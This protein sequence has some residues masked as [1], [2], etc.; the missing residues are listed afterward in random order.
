MKYKKTMYYIYYVL[1][2]LPLAATVVSL[3]FLPECIPAH[4]GENNQVTR[5]GSKYETLIFPA[6]TIIVG[7]VMLG[8]AKSA[9]GKEK[10]KKDSEST[11]IIIGISVL[12]LFDLMTAYFLYADFRQIRNLSEMPADISGLIFCYLGAAVILWGILMPKLKRNSVV[13]LRTKWSMKNDTT[14]E[15]SQRFGGISFVVSGICIIAAG[16]LAEG[17]ACAVWFLGIL[18]ADVVIDVIYTYFAAR[19]YT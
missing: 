18:T 19:R 11:V 17:M 14:W 4:Y 3:L 12:L 16:L 5:W 9:A 13:G 15:K 10:E 7:A 8:I 2:F 1:M 6:E